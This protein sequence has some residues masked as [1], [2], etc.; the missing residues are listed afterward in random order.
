[1]TEEAKDETAN[2]VT[3]TSDAVVIDAPEP[4]TKP[5]ENQ[6]TDESQNDD[7][8]KADDAGEATNSDD[9]PGD[10]TKP[11]DSTEST[12]SDAQAEN[13]DDSETDQDEKKPKQRRSAQKRIDEVIRQ[14]EEAKRENE[15]LQRKIDEMEGKSKAEKLGLTEPVET[16]YDDYDEF[17]DAHDKFEREKLKPENNDLDLSDK[18]EASP[19]E[20]KLTDSQKSAIA[21]IQERL[22][23][24]EDK[25]ED[26]SEI[27]LSDDVQITADMVEA[28]VECDNLIDVMFHLGNN[29]DLAAEIAGK[30]PAQQAREIARLDLVKREK[31]AKP[32][33]TT[34]APEPISPGGSSFSGEKHIK[35]MS[36]SEFEAKQNKAERGGHQW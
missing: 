20:V 23:N 32:A 19:D 24:A 29:R 22:E 16:D 2:F 3:T 28:L 15:E 26:F 21:V 18:S 31:P 27:A 34:N 4:E 1:M 10:D 36:F 33:N 6:T 11:G 7:L 14:R 9:K 5:D 25:P 12:D 35:D 17:L 30:S 8:N 13:S